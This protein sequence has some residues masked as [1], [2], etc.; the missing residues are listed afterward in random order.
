[1]GNY[2]NKKIIYSIN[3][4]DIQEVAQEVL[5]RKLNKEEIIKIKESI[6]DYLDWFQAIEN[7]INK[8]ITTDKHVED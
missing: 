6:G 4:T 1:M 2:R 3:V 5:D 7:S 8:H